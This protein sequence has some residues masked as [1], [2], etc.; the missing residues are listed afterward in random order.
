MVDLVLGLSRKQFLAVMN[1]FQ[2]MEHSLHVKDTSLGLSYS[3]LVN[4]PEAGNPSA[5]R[6]I[7][8]LELFERKH[9][10]NIQERYVAPWT[11]NLRIPT[12]D[13]KLFPV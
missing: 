4:C 13:C 9:E 6:M 7:A 8:K 5:Q 2:A 3:L 10:I 11:Y 12:G 1:F